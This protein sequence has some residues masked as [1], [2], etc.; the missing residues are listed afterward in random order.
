MLRMS[1]RPLQADALVFGHAKYP[2][3]RCPR[4]PL[5]VRGSGASG[6]GSSVF[7]RLSSVFPVSAPFFPFHLRFSRLSS[8]AQPCHRRSVSLQPSLMPASDLLLFQTAGV[9]DRLQ[10]ELHVAAVV[11]RVSRAAQRWAAALSRGA[12]PPS[13]PTEHAPQTSVCSSSA[14]AAVKCAF[15]LSAC[16]LFTGW[17]PNVSQRKVRGAFMS[18]ASSVSATITHVPTISPCVTMQTSLH[19]CFYR[20]N[21]G[22]VGSGTYRFFVKFQSTRAESK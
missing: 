18:A 2:A 16:G 4:S 13:S 14:G 7:P 12:P 10:C 1:E 15:L 8:V 3:L 11:I 9:V 17:L 22:L 19:E 20:P 6:C 21:I 5:C